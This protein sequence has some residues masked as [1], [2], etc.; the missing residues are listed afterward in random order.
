L[1]DST[2][3][4]ISLESLHALPLGWSDTREA[5]M[6]IRICIAGV[7]GWTGSAVARAVLGSRE[8]QLAAGIARR[9]AGE[10]LGTVLGGAPLGLPVVPDLDRALATPFDVLV[11]FT[12]PDSVKDRAL[13]AMAAGRHVVI[14]T[15]GLTASD[16]GDLEAA[17]VAGGVGLIAAGN[18]SITAALAKHFA[19]VAAR[20]LPSCEIIDYAHAEKPDAPNGTTLE[21]AEALG[22]VRPSTLGVALDQIHGFPATR[23][24][25]LAG[26][27]VHSVRLPGYVIAFE[28]IFGLPH[29]R[30]T[31]R[32]DAGAGA[33]PY[34]AGVLL[35]ARK[36]M[37]VKGLVRGLDTLMLQ[38]A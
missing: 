18:F 19:L 3:S 15:S 36:A 14:G 30:L 13:R 16:Y 37:D 29:E 10:D 31:I 8:F 17:A 35:A 4:N 32:H 26:T 22:A 1:D 28:T 2:F 38:D 27:Q 20:Y 6:S 34:V 12:G 9:R 33:D 25:A 24:A 23:G 21:L 5:T 7:T 11:D